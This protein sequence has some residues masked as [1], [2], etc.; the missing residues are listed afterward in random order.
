MKRTLGA[1]CT[2]ALL[3][4]CSG[5]APAP[6]PETDRQA[7]TVTALEQACLQEPTE[8]SRWEQLGAALEAGGERER[9]ATMF[10]QAA[11]L[12]AHDVQRDYALLKEG[13]AQAG[14]AVVDASMPRTEVRKIGAALVE[15]LRVAAGAEAAPVA[16]GVKLEISNGNGVAGAAARLAR[17]LDAEGIKATR[18]TNLKPFVVPVSRIEYQRDQQLLAQTLAQRLGLPL[19]AQNGK[20]V[21]A[22]MR[23]VL[24]RDAVQARYLK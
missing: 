11:T 4:A 5:M 13:A 20:S 12:R 14:A 15:V 17:T 6:A 21:Y 1:A 22:D 8:A 18:L 3:M 23:I 16:Q 9:A 10:R 19:Q 24:G 2:G 7:G